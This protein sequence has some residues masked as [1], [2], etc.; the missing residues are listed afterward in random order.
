MAQ[1]D[2]QRPRLDV[3]GAVDLSALAK[4]TPPPGSPGGLP[5]PGAYVVDVDEASFPELKDLLGLT[6]GNLGAH[7]RT[8]EDAGYV[9]V[10]KGFEGRKP[11][12]TCR[13]TPKGRR[14]LERHV[15]ALDRLLRG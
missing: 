11:R 6:Q 4:P 7:L 13:I 2:P 10:E 9:E 14:A 5:Q 15:A 3:R 12:T 8:L 1:T